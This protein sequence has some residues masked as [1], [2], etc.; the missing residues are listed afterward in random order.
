MPIEVACDE[1]GSEGENL[2]EGGARIFAH[3]STDLNIA[4]AE[5]VVAELRKETGSRADELKSSALLSARNL[6]ILLALFEDDGPLIAHAKVHLTDK[7]YF[8]VSKAIDLVIEEAAYDAGLLLHA[9]GSAAVMAR[10]LFRDGPRAYPP[11]DWARLLRQFVSY[12]R[13]VQ[14]RGVKTSREQLYV[15]IEELRLRARRRSVADIL[16]ALWSA[17]DQLRQ[18]EA[19]TEDSAS[20]PALDPLM[21]GV[22]STATAWYQEHK[23]PL[24]I[25]HDRQS[26]LTPEVVA[27]MVQIA[28]HPHP[29]FPNWIPLVGVVQVDSRTDARVQVADLVAGLGRMVGT[30]ALNGTLGEQL[31]AVIRPI[32]VPDSLWGDPVSWERLTGRA[33][34]G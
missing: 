23:K 12:V 5:A 27:E 6:P 20:M 18:Y 7:L 4:E 13:S 2:L 3:G 28:N 11:D 30:Q 16:Q 21:P 31:T 15:T 34:L 9:D 8:A 24:R 26:A 19:D 22:F 25:I 14:R 17:R 29:E 33:D 32:I 10:T 1:S